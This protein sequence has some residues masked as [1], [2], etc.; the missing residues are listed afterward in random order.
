MASIMG[1]VVNRFM[2]TMTMNPLINKNQLKT[3]NRVNKLTWYKV[4]KGYEQKKFVVDEL[5]MEIIRKKDSESKNVIYILHGG[6]YVSK[7]SSL[8]RLHAKGYSKAGYDASVIYI[9]Y[10]V[11][12]ENKYPAA[13]EDAI[14]GWDWI[15]SQGY[16]EE[17]IIVIGDSAGGHLTLSL[18][19]KLREQKRTMPK[20][21]IC[22]SPWADMTSSADTYYKNYNKD[23]LLG[24][25]KGEFNDEI[26]DMLSNSDMYSFCHGMDLYDPYISPVYADYNDFPPM[27]LI[28]GGNEMVAG[29]SQ[30][31]AEKLTN[32]GSEV[33]LEITPDMFHVF[34]LYSMIIP[35]AK[36]AMKMI[37]S[38]MAKH[39]SNN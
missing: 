8:Y 9:D 3:L 29:D 37:H 21:A 15:L 6:A 32:A 24:N 26:R 17:N 4:P 34:P 19:L 14:K 33:T 7:L 25:K 22:L 12:P 13:L 10:R 1:K 30:I 28:A 2:R 35:E 23:I 5:P 27:L 36:R 38:F 39:L 31:I 11:A 18:M 20:A 16:K